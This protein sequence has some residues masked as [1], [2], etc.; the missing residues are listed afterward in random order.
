LYCLFDELIPG[1][2]IEYMN[3]VKTDSSSA[4]ES[5]LNQ[6]KPGDQLSML[7]G[8]DGIEGT[9]SYIVSFQLPF[10]TNDYKQVEPRKL[11]EVWRV[12]HGIVR[13]TDLDPSSISSREHRQG[14]LKPRPRR[15]MGGSVRK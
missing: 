9:K 10:M 8:S 4:V 2:I 1:H 7:I 15:I 13:K 5:I 11:R 14:I 3:S 6:A 12:Y